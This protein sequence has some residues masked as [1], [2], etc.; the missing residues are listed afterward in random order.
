MLRQS[1]SNFERTTP[2]RTLAA[3]AATDR[4][5]TASHESCGRRANRPTTRVGPQGSCRPPAAHGRPAKTKSQEGGPGR[6]T[7]R[8]DEGR[9]GQRYELGLRGRAGRRPHTGGPPRPRVNRAG[10]AAS[11]ALHP[12]PKGGILQTPRKNGRIDPA[13]GLMQRSHDTRESGPPVKGGLRPAPRPAR[14]PA[15]EPKERGGVGA[16]HTRQR[17]ARAGRK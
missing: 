2:T 9:T 3:S 12:I 6:V 5:F 17:D 8:A 1:V 11:P 14:G 16:R 15:G 7:N 13:R 10:R 4:T